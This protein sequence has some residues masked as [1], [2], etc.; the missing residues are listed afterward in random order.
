MEHLEKLNKYTID[1]IHQT[2]NKFEIEKSQKN[3]IELTNR[4]MQYFNNFTRCETKFPFNVYVQYDE[5]EHVNTIIKKLTS[6]NYTCEHYTA[7]YDGVIIKKDNYL[8]INLPKNEIEEKP[9]EA[10]CE[11][12][13][14]ET[15][16][17]PKE[18]TS[19]KPKE[20]LPWFSFWSAKKTENVEDANKKV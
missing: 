6:L 1:Y 11:K 20:A 15:N 14:E 10:I 12:P 8:K 9:K 17:K 2:K 7:L 3:L 5:M 13:K 18:E 16:E 4:I 19:E